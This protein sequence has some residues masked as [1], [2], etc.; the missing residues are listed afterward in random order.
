MNEMELDPAETDDN[1]ASL[2]FQFESDKDDLVTGRVDFYEDD[3]GREDTI[4]VRFERLFGGNSKCFREKI[5][6]MA[7]KMDW[8]R[9]V[10][11]VEAA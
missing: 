7:S 10:E 11:D 2:L 5:E 6:E 4:L 3:L 9:N 1:S 8:L